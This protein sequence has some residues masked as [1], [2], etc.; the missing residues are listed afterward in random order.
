MSESA[1]VTT[2]G[3]VKSKI[4][5]RTIS[6][7]RPRNGGL[8]TPAPEPAVT[9]PAPKKQQRQT[10][11]NQPEK[12]KDSAQP[13]QSETHTT[14]DETPQPNTYK[15]FVGNLPYDAT[16]EQLKE[17]FKGAGEVVDVNMAEARRRPMGFGFVTYSTQDAANS[18]IENYDSTE[19]RNRK[20]IVEHAI[21]KQSPQYRR[22][23]Q[24]RYK[25]RPNYNN[26]IFSTKRR[27]YQ[28]N[29]DYR[30]NENNKA[31]I[32][33]NDQPNDNV[34]QNGSEN[35][36][37]RSHQQNHQAPTSQN[38]TLPNSEARDE[39]NS[40]NDE[41]HKDNDEDNQDQEQSHSIRN[42]RLRG[43]RPRNRNRNRDRGRNNSRDYDKGPH[44]L[45]TLYVTNLPFDLA[46]DDLKTLFAD[47]N[48][49]N[50][51]IV[52]SK[53]GH[54][55][56]FGFIELVNHEEQLRVLNEVRSL[57][58]SDRTV[59][60]KPAYRSKF[61]KQPQNQSNGYI[62]DDNDSVS[63][64]QQQHSDEQHNKTADGKT[65]H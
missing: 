6:D 28:Y 24:R 26:P 47:Y 22:M 3:P 11:D 14:K 59:L 48:V 54:S 50:V 38:Q 61:D 60:V 62:S 52:H 25:D 7:R 13:E 8:A 10:Y 35:D 36:D 42:N 12:Q 33:D 51:S 21:D 63:E 30:Q 29:N 64:N 39:T 32:D 45:T 27:T 53:E 40:L 58:I 65:T 5:S 34:S 57:I 18:A 37:N 31:R 43:M 41:I 46:A 19:F 1:P 23:K 20:I 9:P 49:V 15:V 17:L 16:C 4:E 55:R 44:S 2:T 56:G